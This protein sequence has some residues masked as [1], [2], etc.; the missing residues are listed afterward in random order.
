MAKLEHLNDSVVCFYDAG[1]IVWPPSLTAATFW[2][3]MGRNLTGDDLKSHTGAEI[4]ER[5]RTKMANK[6]WY[7]VIDEL[8]NLLAN[9]VARTEFLGFLKGITTY[10]QKNVFFGG[11]LGAGTHSL[12]NLLRT[13]DPTPTPTPVT[14]GSTPTPVELVKQLHALPNIFKRSP[15]YHAEFIAMELLSLEQA[16]HYFGSVMKEF[17]MEISPDVQFDVYQFTGGNVGLLSACAFVITKQQF[18]TITM[19]EWEQLK[20]VDVFDFLRLC[21]RMVI[22]VIQFLKS[23]DAGIRQY[24]SMLL[25]ADDSVS[26]DSE[27][28]ET[29]DLLQEAGIAQRRAGGR[30]ALSS[31]YMKM[32]LLS[33]LFDD[34]HPVQQV[35]PTLP[36]GALD[37]YGILTL[38]IR[39]IDASV[40]SS[41][42]TANRESP[43]ESVFQV[44]LYTALRK[45]GKGGDVK[46]KTFAEVK[47][48]DS[49]SEQRLDLMLRSDDIN[50]G[51]FELKVNK[52]KRKEIIDAA[53]NQ[54]EN[55]RV[56]HDIRAMFLVNFV[57]EG[58]RMDKGLPAKIGDVNIIYV[59]HDH[60]FRNV[61]ISELTC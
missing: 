39:L 15:F 36:S 16:G 33:L 60:A 50:F 57:P 44:E 34:I 61:R 31:P 42:F 3:A 13:P 40:I 41:A 23:I 29:I 54:A 48:S 38:A 52:L 59:T 32:L 58:H 47:K 14:Q 35:L 7:L 43:S 17:N 51:G 56:Y 25:Q 2:E 28:S 26:A 12:Q 27:D 6:R 9:D 46:F 20:L 18:K 45:L 11:F 24:I 4:A 1:D 8:G 37:P 55:Y 49:G 30:L 10:S 21:N 5:I 22:R 53:K 19:Q